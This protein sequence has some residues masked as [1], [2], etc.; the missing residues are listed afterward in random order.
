[1]DFILFEQLKLG[2]NKSLK[3]Y[4]D[5]DYRKEIN[6]QKKNYHYNLIIMTK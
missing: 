5:E 1:M 2:Y 4:E 3:Y 6:N